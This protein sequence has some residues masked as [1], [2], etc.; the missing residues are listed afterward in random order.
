MSSATMSVRQYCY[1]AVYVYL[2][3]SGTLARTHEIYW[4]SSNPM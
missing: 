3:I 1:I 4:N 2:F